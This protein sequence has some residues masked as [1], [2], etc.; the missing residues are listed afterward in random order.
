MITINLPDDV[1]RLVYDELQ[2]RLEFLGI[3]GDMDERDPSDIH[4]RVYRAIEA[5]LNELDKAGSG[6]SP[7]GTY[8][9]LPPDY[10]E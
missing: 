6:P 9:P 1:A 3:E 8:R 5:T 7:L 2:G 4:V 10:V